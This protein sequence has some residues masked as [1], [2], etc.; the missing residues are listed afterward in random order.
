MAEYLI[1]DT[2]WTAIGNAIRAKDGT[3][4]PILGAEIA[5]RIAA[6]KTGVTV[7]RASGTFTT[8]SR[9]S[10]TVNCGFQPDFVILTKNETDDEGFFYVAAIPFL[11]Y[12][13]KA[14]GIPMWSS[15]TTYYLYDISP[16]RSATG[17]TVKAARY[18][19]NWTESNLANSSFSYIAY[20]I[21]E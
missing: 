1:Q 10:A 5:S 4:E 15:N 6:I 7:Q 8:D 2:T 11:D 18:N 21:T 20:K 17:F 19:G 16:T 13:D 9:G 12:S 3:S 14:M